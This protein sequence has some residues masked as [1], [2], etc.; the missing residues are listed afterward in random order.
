MPCNHPGLRIS[1]TAIN[2]CKISRERLGW[3]IWCKAPNT[4]HD[5]RAQKNAPNTGY[6][7]YKVH[8]VEAGTGLW[9]MLTFFYKSYQGKAV[10]SILQGG[11]EHPTSLC[12]HHATEGLGDLDPCFALQNTEPR[13]AVPMHTLLTVMGRMQ[14]TSITFIGVLNCKEWLAW[15]ERVYE[16]TEGADGFEG[17]RGPKTPTYVHACARTRTPSDCIY[18]ENIYPTW[19]FICL[20][21]N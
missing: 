15:T 1:Q 4:I 13:V 18:S 2:V 12:P 9:G 7:T 21:N 5:A 17:C 6:T 19:G 14:G 3:S 10:Y 20:G 16:Q 11:L 8:I